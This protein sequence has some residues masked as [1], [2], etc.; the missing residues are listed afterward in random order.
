MISSSVSQI[1]I[2]PH[3]LVLIGLLGLTGLLHG[4]TVGELESMRNQ[5]GWIIGKGVAGD[6]SQADRLAISDLLNQ[7]S[8]QVE[9]SYESMITESDGNVKD[10]CKSVIKTYSCTQLDAAEKNTFEQGDGCVVYRFIRKEDKDK[11][12]ADREQMIRDYARQGADA[13]SEQRIGDALLNDYW[14]LILLRTHP[15]WN[16]IRETLN[17]REQT[18]ITYLPDRICRLLSLLT[19]TLEPPY[20]S[21]DDQESLAEIHVNF[22]GQPVRNLDIKYYSGNDW[23][24]SVGLCEGKA[25]LEFLCRPETISSPVKIAV[26]Y[27]YDERKTVNAD[28]AKVMDEVSRPVFPKCQFK[29]IWNN[30]VENTQSPA[31]LPQSSSEPDSLSLDVIAATDSID[32]SRYHQ[33]AQQLCRALQSKDFDS[34]D[35]LCTED[36]ERFFE[37]I[38]NNGKGKIVGA[39]ASITCERRGGKT[40]VRGLSMQFAFPKSGRSF[41]EPMVFT[42]D[43]NDKLEKIAF[44][45]SDTATDNILNSIQAT[46]AQRELIRTFIE[47]YKTAYCLKDLSFV[48]KVFA[49][50]ALIIVGSMLKDDPTDIEG[51][52][53]KL[54]KRWKATR[55]SKQEYVDNLRRTFQSNEYVN[56]KFED[57]AIIR[58]NDPAK[59][60]FGIQIHQ[61]YYSQRYADEGYLFLMFDLADSTKPK[62]YVRTWQP[63]KFPDGTIYGLKDF[64]VN[65]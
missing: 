23:S 39:A 7:I 65:E 48:E 53:Q 41:V 20:W 38:V 42:F 6:E 43:K 54:G 19:L 61:Y 52:Y 26:E 25:L 8:V 46:P 18:L 47:D 56:L 33:V 37:K 21:E 30:P 51:M 64:F 24:Q 35:D 22:Q 28:I 49:D 31:L 45:L 40:V 32:T 10:F 62:I 55:Y 3:F 16:H 57:N 2:L 9:S 1:R 14:S 29:V 15:G 27:S 50:N 59:S 12:F 5:P 34:V 44:G 36:G 58:T 60:V 11:I 4:Y 63:E 17:G 13:E